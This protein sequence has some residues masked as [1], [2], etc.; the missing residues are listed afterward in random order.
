MR[1]LNGSEK[2]PIKLE[3]YTICHSFKVK[4]I[5]NSLFWSGTKNQ[6]S[7]EAVVV[8]RALAGAVVVV[9]G[10]AALTAVAPLEATSLPPP[11][12]TRAKDASENSSASS[13]FFIYQFF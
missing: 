3:F 10:A 5:K 12:E 11:Q 1:F 6:V 7:S 2:L 13:F 4:N 8:D 9:T